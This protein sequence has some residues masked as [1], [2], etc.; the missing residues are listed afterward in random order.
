M[1]QEQS[2]QVGSLDVAGIAQSLIVSQVFKAGRELTSG[3]RF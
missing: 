1:F 3:L 2:I